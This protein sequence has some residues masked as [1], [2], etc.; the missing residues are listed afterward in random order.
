M[1]D[2]FSM[3]WDFVKGYE[4]LGDMGANLALIASSNLIRDDDWDDDEDYLRYLTG[5]YSPGHERLQ[6]NIEIPKKL[7]SELLPE[8]D[9]D[10]RPRLT[11]G[12]PGQK[13]NRVLESVLMAM[14][15]RGGH[16]GKWS[17]RG[18]RADD[19]SLLD[20][21][22]DYGFSGPS[23]PMFP[24]TIGSR[25]GGDAL[26]PHTKGWG[27]TSLSQREVYEDYRQRMLPFVHHALRAGSRGDMVPVGGTM[28]QAL[29]AGSPSVGVI[30]GFEGHQFGLASKLAA[31]Q[32]IGGISSH[33]TQMGHKM[34]QRIGEIP[35]IESEF[36]T[37]R[38][39]EGGK[40]QSTLRMTEPG[41][42][43]NIPDSQM[44][45][46]RGGR[47]AAKVVGRNL[48]YFSEAQRPFMESF[49]GRWGN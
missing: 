3:A 46:T 10:Y 29:G 21:E 43:L 11:R 23:M 34:N 27:G 25:L 12:R 4:D 48:D 26:L 33:A 9:P 22:S 35:G 7:A 31:L 42:L 32:D 2:A 44:A 40:G 28:I 14:G 39:W 45:V 38:H 5:K 17:D 36:H 49:S 47:D 41:D 19:P 1:V 20:S 18:M 15:Y 13:M 24:S 30:P 37:P 6:Y 8:P 16:W